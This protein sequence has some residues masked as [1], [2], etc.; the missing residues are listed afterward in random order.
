M[1]DHVGKCSKPFSK[2]YFLL[3]T[4]YFN[5]TLI[6]YSYTHRLPHVITF[7][8]L[9]RS[10]ERSLWFGK[11]E[12]DALLAKKRSGGTKDA[13]GCTCPLAHCMTWNRH[14][15]TDRRLNLVLS[16]VH[17]FRPVHLQIFSAP[18]R[19][20]V[21]GPAIL[22]YLINL[23]FIYRSHLNLRLRFRIVA[24]MV[25]GNKMVSVFSVPL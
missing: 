1:T 22:S 3:Y 4:R 6:G 8:L 18:F 13:T 19:S 12:N 7:V 25:A 5:W 14:K 15:S 24:A 23:R 11:R 16:S 21:F 20:F 17:P 2:N 10:Y 9:F